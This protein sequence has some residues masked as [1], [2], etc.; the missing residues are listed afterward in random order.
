MSAGFLPDDHQLAALMADPA[1]LAADDLERLLRAVVETE[2]RVSALR[3][4]LHT[5]IDALRERFDELNDDEEAELVGL[6]QHERRVSQ[7][8]HL[9]HWQ[10]AQ[11]K[12]EQATRPLPPV[13][14]SHVLASHART[15]AGS[16]GTHASML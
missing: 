15:E 6:Q 13:V 7:T 11:V 2:A 3:R 1:G 4:R 5:E 16:G 12:R 8:R 14:A 9:L 10:L